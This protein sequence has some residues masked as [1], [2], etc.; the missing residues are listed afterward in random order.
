MSAPPSLTDLVAQAT[1]FASV[2]EDA[3]RAIAA[4]MREAKYGAGQTIFSRGDDGRDVY[5]VMEGRVRLSVLTAEGRELSF[6]HAERGAL[7]GEIAM[8]DGGPR[9]ADATAATK[10]VAGTLSRT[11]F[12]RLA[13]RFP[14]IQGAMVGFLCQRIREADQ[15]L[16]AIALCPI[17]VRLARFFLANARAVDADAEAQV[18]VPFKMSQTELAMLIGASRPK[19]NTALSLLEANGALKRGKDFVDCQLEPLED[20]AEAV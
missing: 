20:L 19:V 7:F 11:A 10:V 14:A 4:E 18:R 3:G 9:T 13:E 2:G 8:L 6:A 17:E 1:L 5:L 15:Q 12:A 16:E